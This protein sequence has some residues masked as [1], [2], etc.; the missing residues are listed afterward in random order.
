M[1][2]ELTGVTSYR[3]SLDVVSL[4]AGVLFIA[5]ALYWGLADRPESSPNGWFLPVVLIGIGVLGLLSSRRRR[6]RQ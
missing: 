2:T 6:D 5:A 1:S 3:H 4:T